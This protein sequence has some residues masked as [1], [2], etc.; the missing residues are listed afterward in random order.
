[1]FERLEREVRKTVED[2]VSKIRETIDIDSPDVSVSGKEKKYFWISEPELNVSQTH[3]SILDSVGYKV[4]LTVY[5]GGLNKRSRKALWQA[6]N[7]AFRIRANAFLRT[8]KKD[9]LSEFTTGLFVQNV[10][11]SQVELN[12]GKVVLEIDFK[13]NISVRVK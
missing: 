1:M 13:I 10:N 4:V 12:T 11:R 9:F 5:D 3:Q 2:S 8:Q 6:Y 7:D